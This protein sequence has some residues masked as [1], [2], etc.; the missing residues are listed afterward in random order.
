MASSEVLADRHSP[1]SADE[2][3]ISEL[4]RRTTMVTTPMLMGNEPGG[5]ARE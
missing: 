1:V 5:P 2:T 4:T 3:A